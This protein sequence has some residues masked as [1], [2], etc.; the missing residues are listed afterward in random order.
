[1][2]YGFSN[3]ETRPTVRAPHRTKHILRSGIRP[4]FNYGCQRN[5]TC[6]C[7]FNYLHQIQVIQKAFIRRYVFDVIPISVRS[8]RMNKRS[9]GHSKRQRL[10]LVSISVRTNCVLHRASVTAADMRPLC[11]ML[12]VH[13]PHT[14]HCQC[15]RH[16]LDRPSLVDVHSNRPIC[17][18]FAQRW[19]Y[20]VWT[21][22]PGVDGRTGGE[23]EKSCINR[24]EAFAIR[25]SNFFSIF[26]IDGSDTQGAPT[27][28]SL[29]PRPHSMRP[30][31]I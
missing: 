6:E 18:I 2:L 26:R 12:D 11:R 10:L 28:S 22:G 30:T 21:V 4:F 24:P 20:D 16:A 31:S 27:S 14:A 17:R 13:V 9:G 25:D 7:H 29:P 8:E 23:K 15:I 19:I 5:A 1:M 3:S